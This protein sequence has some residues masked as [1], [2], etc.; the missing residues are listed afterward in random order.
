MYH[1]KEEKILNTDATALVAD[2]RGH[3][4]RMPR[5]ARM[6]WWTLPSAPGI[7]DSRTRGKAKADGST[8][9]NRLNHPDKEA[10]AASAF[11]AFTGLYRIS[12]PLHRKAS[13]PLFLSRALSFFW[14]ELIIIYYYNYNIIIL[15]I[16]YIYNYYIIY[17]Y[18]IILL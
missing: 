16:I 15:Y 9:D 10:I 17:Y 8:L 13:S 2:W 12:Q 11:A 3:R 7:E 5:T 14:R 4:T 18:I 6:L 1:F